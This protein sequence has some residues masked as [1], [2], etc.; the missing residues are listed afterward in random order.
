[1]T[2]HDRLQ[3]EADTAWKDLCDCMLYWGPADVE[4]AEK[5]WHEAE[6]ALEESERNEK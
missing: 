6:K 4:R 1:M 3:H 5:R 2:E